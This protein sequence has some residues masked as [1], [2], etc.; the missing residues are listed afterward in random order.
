LTGYNA[1]YQGTGGTAAVILNV[2]IENQPVNG[3]QLPRQLNLDGSYEGTA[4]Q[5]ELTFSSYQVKIH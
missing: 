5:M 2:R 1:T 3:M 4:F